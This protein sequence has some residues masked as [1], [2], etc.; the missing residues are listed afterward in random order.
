[1]RPYWL[2]VRSSVGRFTFLPAVVLGLMVLFYRNRYWIGIWPETGAA[3][4]VSAFFMSLLGAGVSAWAAARIDVQGLREQSDTAVVHPTLVEGHRFA[5]NLSWLLAAYAVVVAVS[6]G[7]T[8]ARSFPPGVWF[9]VG[10]VA[11]GVILIVLSAAWGWMAGRLLS[12]V[13]AGLCSALSWFIFVSTVGQTAD[14]APVSGP[15]WLDLQVPV[16]VVRLA[17]VLAFALVVC[18]VPAGAAV[19]RERRVRGLGAAVAGLVIVTLTHLGTAVLAPRAPVASP[20]CVRG[21]IEY[22]LWPEH[23]KYV[24]LVKDVDAEVADL[25]LTLELPDRIVDYSLSGAV[26]GVF[27]DAELLSSSGFPPE[28]D[29]SEGSRWALARGVAAA[30]TGS[31]FSGCD[32][33]APFDPE[34]RSDQLQAWLEWRL[35]GGGVPDYTTDAPADLQRAWAA[36]HRAAAGLDEAQQSAWAADLI[37]VTTERYCHV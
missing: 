3:V 32:P 9:F 35:A 37:T 22:C 25:P 28:F 31:V 21:E 33:R 2:H 23:E 36:G 4:A 11:L 30:I 10:Y 6:Y 15:P 13:V 8:A 27:G 20:T 24:P 17:A 26:Q 14:A 5:G 19:S 12:P 29:V 7:V 18:A 34:L 16:L 1:V